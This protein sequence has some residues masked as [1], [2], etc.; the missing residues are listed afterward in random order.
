M[1]EQNE[2]NLPVLN[3][4]TYYQG[5]KTSP[6]QARVEQQMNQNMISND[7]ELMAMRDVIQREMP[8]MQFGF[9]EDF[10]QERGLNNQG[11]LMDF[12]SGFYNAGVQAVEGITAL[13]GAIG[14]MSGAGEGSWADKWV[15]NVDKWAD[16]LE[17]NYSD[18]GQKG[19]FGGGGLAGLWAGFGNGI[20]TVATIMLGGGAASKL[21][22]GASAIA[23]AGQ[24]VR[25]L[26][27]VNKAVN[28]SKWSTRV[29][30]F[31]TGTAQMYPMV[32]DEA[33]AAGI[34]PGDAMRYAMSVAGLISTT[35]V[36]GLEWIG[37]T[38]SKPISQKAARESVRETLL[39]A[40]KKGLTAETLTNT[41]PV[42]LKGYANKMRAYGPK[43]FEGMAVE[44]TQEFAQTYIEEG[45]K[46]MWNATLANEK[47][48]FQGPGIGSWDTFLKAVEGGLIGGLVGGSMGGGGT[49]FNAKL[50][51]RGIQGESAYNIVKTDVEKGSSKNVAALKGMVLKSQA[52][53]DYTQEEAL[54][55]NSYIDDMYKF[56]V[57]TKGIPLMDGISN[58]QLYQLYQTD[59]TIKKTEELQGARM[60]VDNPV[61]TKS[62]KVREDKA[63]AITAQ[64]SGEMETIIEKGK[65]TGNREEFDK[66]MNGYIRLYE[67]VA[68]NKVTS[69]QLAT[70]LESLAYN[71]DAAKLRSEK[72]APQPKGQ[73]AQG[74]M[75]ADE[76]VTIKGQK[77]SKKFVDDNNFEDV[78]NDVKKSVVDQ[79]DEAQKEKG[80]KELEAKYGE[81]YDT[82][83]EMYDDMPTAE[84]EW[85]DAKQKKAEPK[86]TT[87][88]I[89]N[90]VPTEDLK[91]KD[92]KIVDEIVES[93]KA[94]K[95]I[96]SI[97]TIETN[98]GKQHIVDGH[99]R[100]L[101]YKKAGIKNIP[102]KKASKES[103]EKWEEKNNSYKDASDS[104]LDMAIKKLSETK[105]RTSEED[106]FLSQAKEEKTRRD[107]KKNVAPKNKYS[108]LVDKAVSEKELDAITDQSTKENLYTPELMEK[109]SKKRESFSKPKKRRVKQAMVRP[110]NELKA[111][112]ELMKQ[113][114]KSP[115]TDAKI[116]EFEKE[117]AL[118]EKMGISPDKGRLEDI[119]EDEDE[120]ESFAS[121]INDIIQ[122]EEVSETIDNFSN[123][124]L[125]RDGKENLLL[126]DI[127][128]IVDNWGI[129]E[130]S[131]SDYMKQ[132]GTTL[133][134]AVWRNNKIDFFKILENWKKGKDL[135]N[136]QTENNEQVEKDEQEL[137]PLKFEELTSESVTEEGK[138][139]LKELD[140]VIDSAIKD[141]KR[142]N[143]LRLFPKKLQKDLLNFANKIGV[144]GYGSKAYRF[145]AYNEEQLQEIKKDLQ[146]VIYQDYDKHLVN[147]YT[148][149]PPIEEQKVEEPSGQLDMFPSDEKLKKL[150]KP[151][152][153]VPVK[154]RKPRKSKE[155]RTYTPN[156]TV[157][158][159]I[160]EN[161]ELYG[162]IVKHFQKIFPG[163]PVR[164]L[165]EMLR[166][167]GPRVLGRLIEGIIEIDPKNARQSTIIHEYAHVFVELLGKNHPWVK[168]GLKAV[169]GTLYDQW[170]KE[171][172]PDKTREEQ[173]T[174]ALVQAIAETSLDSLTRNFNNGRLGKFMDWLSRFWTKVKALFPKTLAPDFVKL[175]SDSMTF[176]NQSINVP[177]GRLAGTNA[178][179]R[180][181]T[182]QKSL[183]D[184]GV[185]S[186][187]LRRIEMMYNNDYLG[188]DINPRDPSVYYLFALSELRRTFEREF[189][190]D[191]K[192]TIQG[193]NNINYVPTGDEVKDQNAFNMA[194]ISTNPQ[195]NERL[196]RA[197]TNIANSN[198]EIKFDED[199]K[200]IIAKDSA[201]AVKRLRALNDTITSV[202]NSLVDDE[203]HLIGKDNVTKYI[204]DIN[205]Q[206]Y[207]LVELINEDARNNGSIESVRL[208]EL[209]KELESTPDVRQSFV[210]ELHS[211]AQEKS[212]AHIIENKETVIFRSPN[213]AELESGEYSE[214]D[215]VKDTVMLPR[216]FSKIQNKNEKIVSAVTDVMNQLKEFKSDFKTYFNEVISKVEKYFLIKDNG[217]M[218][219][220][221]KDKFLPKDEQLEPLKYYDKNGLTDAQTE[222]VYDYLESNFKEFVQAINDILASSQ[223]KITPEYINNNLLGKIP[224]NLKATN[225]IEYK[226]QV[227]QKKTNMMSD[228]LRAVKNVN[229][230]NG[231]K[232]DI[233]S[234]IKG[235][236]EASD[237][238]S[239]LSAGFIG[240]T[241]ANKP[242]ISLG[243]YLSDISRLIRTNLKHQAEMLKNKL[244]KNNPMVKKIINGKFSYQI[245]DG[246][247]NI[248]TN[249]SREY[250]KFTETD[251]LL[252]ALINYSVGSETEYQQN[253]MINA[254][255]DM[256]FTVSATRYTTDEQLKNEL[257]NIKSNL[258]ELLDKSKDK[259]KT[260]ETIKNTSLF[261]VVDGKVL[262]PYDKGVYSRNDLIKSAIDSIKQILK[263]TN[264]EHTFTA[265]FMNKHSTLD[266]KK[267]VDGKVVP[268]IEKI[269]GH[270]LLNDT[271]N[272]IYATDILIGQ[273]ADYKNTFDVIKR[274]GGATSNGTLVQVPDVMV[275]VIDT[276][277]L[278]D[279]MSINGSY[280][281]DFIKEKIGSLDKVGLNMKD[282]VFQVQPDGKSLFLKMS[283]V[284]AFRN[285]DTTSLAELN[286]DTDSEFNYKNI[287]DAII[288]LENLIEQKTGKKQKIKI[289]DSKAVK[290]TQQVSKGNIMTLNDFMTNVNNGNLD[291]VNKSSMTTDFNGY[292][293]PF[294]MTK[295]IS[296][297]EIDK[298]KSVASTQLL[299]ILQSF[300]TNE[301]N[302]AFE[303]SIV[304]TLLSN[305]GVPN[306][307]GISK[308]DTYKDLNSKT[309]FIKKMLDD[310]GDRKDSQITKLMREIVKWNETIQAQLNDAYEIKNNKDSSEKQ[311]KDANQ[312]ISELNDEFAYTA[313]HPK[314]KHIMEQMV[315]SSLHR[316]GIRLE[317]P[318]QYLHNIPNYSADL[319]WYRTVD[320]KQEF[321]EVGMPWSMFGKT[322]EEAE[323][324]LRNN[325]SLRD[326][327]VV[328]VPA[329]GP[330]SG[331]RGRVKYLIDGDS[332]TCILP[333]EFMDKAGADNDGDKTFVYRRDI[334]KSG[335]T[336]DSAANKIV[337]FFLN[338]MSKP[339]YIE[340]AQTSVDSNEFK[341]FL[342][343]AE[344]YNDNSYTVSNPVDMAT[345]QSKMN[346][347][348]DGIGVAAVGM[349]MMNVLSQVGAK[350]KAPI[351][352]NYEFDGKERKFSTDK[353]LSDF[354][355]KQFKDMALFV[356][357]I[358]DMIKDPYIL[359]MGVNQNNL[360][361]AS[362]L[363][364]LGVDNKSIT[365]F[366]TDPAIVRYQK[367]VDESNNIYS[368]DYSKSPKTLLEEYVKKMEG[369]D[370]SNQRTKA[371]LFE[372]GLTEPIFDSLPPGTYQ[373]NGKSYNVYAVTVDGKKGFKRA[374]L[375][376][377]QEQKD[378]DIIKKFVELQA[379]ASDVFDLSSIVQM[380]GSLPNSSFEARQKFEKMESIKKGNSKIDTGTFFERPLFNH[381]Y[382]VLKAE[383]DL[384]KNRFITN[385]DE[386]NSI[387]NE[388]KANFKMPE[389]KIKKQIDRVFLNILFEKFMN[390]EFQRI[391]RVLGISA[392]PIENSKQF[393]NR[394]SSMVGIAQKMAK[395]KEFDILNS[396]GE[397]MVTGDIGFNEISNAIKESSSDTGKLKRIAL[398]WQNSGE[399]A[400]E[401]L[402]P[403]LNKNIE[404]L[405]TLPADIKTIGDNLFIQS[406]QVETKTNKSGEEITLIKPRNDYYSAS[407][408]YREM[409]QKAFSELPMPVQLELLQ[410][411]VLRHG[412]SDARGTL[413]DMIPYRDLKNTE[414]GIDLSKFM[415]YNTVKHNK[416]KDK[417][418]FGK[419]FLAK[420][421][422][423]LK[424]NVMLSLQGKLNNFKLKKKVY[425]KFADSKGNI[426]LK[427]LM[428]STQMRDFGSS[429]YTNEQLLE[430]VGKT[431]SSMDY[432][433][434]F[435][436]AN[437]NNPTSFNLTVDGKK[438][439]YEVN[440]EA[441]KSW[442][443]SAPRDAN[444]SLTE[445]MPVTISPIDQGSFEQTENYTKYDLMKEDTKPKEIMKH[446]VKKII[447]GGQTG[448]DVAG[449]DASLEVGIPTGGTAAAKFQ[450]STKGDKKIFSPELA[451]KYGLKEGSITKREGKFGPYDDVYY[452]RTIDNS[453]EADGTIWF[454]KSDSPGGR[455]TLGNVAQNSKPKALVNPK[456][457]EEIIEWLV[458]N[459]IQVLNVAGNREHT[460]PGIY[461]KAKT[462][463][464][465]ALK[466]TET[467]SVLK[468]APEVTEQMTFAK[469]M[470]EQNPYKQWTENSKGLI[471]RGW[472]MQDF[473]NSPS[474]V[475]NNELK[476]II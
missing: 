385:I 442:L 278:S 458:N 303:N 244:Y 182:D 421:M 294:N 420:N 131:V 157:D 218:E 379:I 296:E 230:Y 402:V 299:K 18:A 215:T 122:S 26:D 154:S 62:Y 307:E 129:D 120:G 117:I 274:A 429:Q 113:G 266:Y 387:H 304:E 329:S 48:K 10:V 321:P 357:A 223:I 339:E 349:K 371:V 432:G 86:V 235:I 5:L 292:R 341:E 415:K 273:M 174:E 434:F 49:F 194:F 417:N 399:I 79:T 251:M 312:K 91:T 58:Y 460:N 63:K 310:S 90:F 316:D 348:Q 115:E 30:G 228:I 64:L 257:N 451:K 386:V 212:N 110:I 392:K 248:E 167:G 24:G 232:P 124:N 141:A 211:L 252:N 466:S 169:E 277:G 315:A 68:K 332:N 198:T 138:K 366:L 384:Y 75:S 234:Y 419:N 407:Q 204:T 439:A 92:E 56:A 52:S 43:I 472:T 160:S 291:A 134:K 100:Y 364:Q 236:V 14:L 241:G 326:V 231:D 76:S 359:G 139:L 320:G 297:K 28:T 250:G 69:E 84:K 180:I 449:L 11:G 457:A 163:V 74:T 269:I 368:T 148:E 73:K 430:L 350:L 443:E 249:K 243:D 346:F 153:K 125:D 46:E 279:S 390:K 445:S 72:I 162:R 165:N 438:L 83:A 179:M 137:Q 214:G 424:K 281:A 37:N 130:Q 352:F 284:N 378:L 2:N 456:S 306:G 226:R 200:D 146:Q 15:N 205:Q 389:D 440:M 176:A 221:P 272:R 256:M 459:N 275:I 319:K 338:Q 404:F 227:I 85:N 40:S 135:K 337:D 142:L 455:L 111:E 78:M 394:V 104:S 45:A 213:E 219:I 132:Q 282:V 437:A 6:E 155:Q 342:E 403:A 61:L 293:I 112:I 401:E 302:T 12:M 240:V 264:M 464:I 468:S 121:E 47:N 118:Q 262:S 9:S 309:N 300:S 470:I 187:M 99:H 242:S 255:R 159:L 4:G 95:E 324:N 469:A 173:L 71:K 276:Q 23:K 261:D 347:A 433:S 105:N 268:N 422:P 27:V 206:G 436:F 330:M 331:F 305:L 247:E 177:I 87:A 336:K 188:Q 295:N 259:A 1:I 383:N 54:K 290:G 13:P 467:N 224:A 314:M 44:G 298:Q 103:I 123:T 25:A 171:T 114:K 89:E 208:S 36:V 446:N 222:E 405:E 260:I 328:R 166:N 106:F 334:D 452:Q 441:I 225:P 178:E 448:V 150:I 335:T 381:Y 93:I 164:T 207:D 308:S 175:L 447:S 107:K 406:L 323:E 147:K 400:Y 94:G 370:I 42:S 393:I 423:I 81:S 128:D 201:S 98:D 363:L 191:P 8:G 450:Q 396:S 109:I 360:G 372:A 365:G 116:A 7:V 427:S 254:D 67:K 21:A 237:N 32:Y 80:K 265:M 289:V 108:D 271:I 311:I 454:G 391:K 35:E 355:R 144:F 20:G 380:D 239:E 199:G 196:S 126:D 186:M 38:I 229:R 267:T 22:G 119:E 184:V 60:L 340:Q 327:A 367:L 270:F 181:N 353:Y 145:I 127:K 377:G 19:V 102:F 50:L 55:I 333:K 397:P 53:G 376:S 428:N 263:N 462:M 465:E 133:V 158:S 41:I 29:G 425:D 463:L 66:K 285:G 185:N 65:A 238:I 96:E 203:G 57:S 358:V 473:V 288:K 168:A 16:G 410:Y 217:I 431:I 461:D 77:V 471:A 220:R 369:R 59:N 426:R 413:F 453:Q 475:R 209:F 190:D 374:E 418:A 287:G 170:A 301:D 210:T 149:E 354:T 82:L 156:S 51:G 318:G 373:F 286:G 245:L 351:G 161:P 202:I 31:M 398:E 3:T 313:D 356:Q 382:N 197:A 444:G 140:E 362:L 70:E 216:V 172:Y 97:E 136:Q 192:G 151:N 195:V 152:K 183:M 143:K 233:H 17:I 34:E 476:C 344:L 101:A 375:I 474:E 193:F 322:R 414:I 189:K 253:P 412:T 345:T 39:E 395:G 408:S 409:V 33:R 388:I 411:Q 280:L 416:V 258:Q 317:I 435:N 361:V 343:K 325:P 283:S 246:V 88:P